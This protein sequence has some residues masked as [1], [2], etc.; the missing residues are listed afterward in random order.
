[1]LTDRFGNIANLSRFNF[2]TLKQINVENSL[3]FDFNTGLLNT[4]C[5]VVLTLLVVI[6]CLLAIHYENRNSNSSLF[7]LLLYFINFLQEIES[8]FDI[9]NMEDDDR[10]KLL[11]LADHQMDVR[12]TC[13]YNVILFQ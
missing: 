6:R 3:I 10:N 7:L 11:R 13:S 4:R 5:T 1:M 8:I 2:P 12:N 9:M